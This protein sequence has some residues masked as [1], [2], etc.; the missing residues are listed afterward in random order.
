MAELQPVRFLAKVSP[1]NEG[2]IAGFTPD[3]VQGMVDRKVAERVDKNGDPLPAR[4]KK[5]DEE[6]DMKDKAKTK[7]KK[8]KTKG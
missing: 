1:Y 3:I 5:A 6:K 7:P 8:G 2:E 4:Q